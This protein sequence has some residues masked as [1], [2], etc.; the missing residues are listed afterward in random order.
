MS[1][2]HGCGVRGTPHLFNGP[3]NTDRANLLIPVLMG[4]K[5]SLG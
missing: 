2:G 3:M 5:S 4:P 1:P